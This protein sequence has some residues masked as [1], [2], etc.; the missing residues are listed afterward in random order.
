MKAEDR[1]RLCAQAYSE[2][3]DRRDAA[4]DAAAA[5]GYD[6][7]RIEVQLD[8]AESAGEALAELGEAARSM[9]RREAAAP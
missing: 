4:A 5:S 3:C 7:K 1:L 8:A 6:A 2:A 9:F